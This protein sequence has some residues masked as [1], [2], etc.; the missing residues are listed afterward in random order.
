MSTNGLPSALLKKDS[1]S[2]YEYA[3]TVA[4]AYGMT[5]EQISYDLRKRLKNGEIV[6]Q[7]WGQYRE[8]SEK[9]LYRY[10]YSE[11]SNHIADVLSREFYDLDFRIFEYVQLNDF[12]NHLAGHNTIFL[13]VENELIDYV[14][15]LI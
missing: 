7:G 13:S 3:A 8:A 5:D 14:Y 6:R 1:F 4:G 12:M 15:F 10:Q 11:L 2:R 9:Q